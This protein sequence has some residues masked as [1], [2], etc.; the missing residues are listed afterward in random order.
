MVV[1]SNTSGDIVKKIVLGA[2][3]HDIGKAIIEDNH[4]LHIYDAEKEREKAEKLIEEILDLENSKD[5]DDYKEFI[6]HS[7]LYHHFTG[8][9]AYKRLLD[10]IRIADEQASSIRIEDENIEKSNEIHIIYPWSILTEETK[11]IGKLYG[12]IDLQNISIQ[13][14]EKIKEFLKEIPLTLREYREKWVNEYQ[15]KFILELKKAIN[16]KN[17]DIILAVLY[18]YLYF[19]PE[20]AGYNKVNLFSLAFHLKTTAML[21]D[22]HYKVNEE[23]KKVYLVDIDIVGTHNTI[24]AFLRKK[25]ELEED[26]EYLKKVNYLSRF[27]DILTAYITRKILQEANSYTTNILFLSGSRAKLVVALDDNQKK[28]IEDFINKINKKIFISTLGNLFVV[29]DFREIDYDRDKLLENIVNKAFEHSDKLEIQKIEKMKELSIFLYDSLFEEIGEGI[30]SIASEY[31]NFYEEIRNKLEEKN[32]ISASDLPVEDDDENLKII[33]FE[34]L[35]NEEK[36]MNIIYLLQDDS[37]IFIYLE[38]GRLKASIED[39]SNI[40]D[41]TKKVGYLKI[42]GDKVGD[43]FGIIFKEAISE[44]IGELINILDNTNKINLQKLLILRLSELLS[45]MFKYMILKE[46][47]KLNEDN[48]EKN[49]KYIKAISVVY[50][51][52]DELLAIGDIELLL[53]F[54]K[55]FLKGKEKLLLNVIKTSAA[56]LYTHYK[57]PFNFAYDKIRELPDEIKIEKKE[58][59]L[60]EENLK[61]G[62]IKNAFH[63]YLKMRD[64]ILFLKGKIIGDINYIISTLNKIYELKKLVDGGKLHR[65]RLVNIQIL[66]YRSIEEINNNKIASLIYLVYYARKDEDDDN[67]NIKIFDELIKELKEKL[68]PQYDKKDEIIKY[69]EIWISLLDFVKVCTRS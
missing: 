67:K 48:K 52:G 38:T 2:L 44:K 60:V 21:A 39:I 33:P 43:L 14:E 37:C 3:L 49:N 55:I 34:Y 12:L 9:S 54:Y 35:L 53:E 47:H 19:Y 61:N 8:K 22:L 10:Y 6:K 31:K 45:F 16:T 17:P 24:L 50:N 59:K 56:F 1:S 29:I 15:E 64:G 41:V 68:N 11:Y 69:I 13:D 42:D 66:L 62:K 51:S 26:G 40:K 30:K 4:N 46:A 57:H 7:I 65:V 28:K 58:Y 25:K 36:N 20:D 63:E 23:K 18:K 5:L 32:I 27:I